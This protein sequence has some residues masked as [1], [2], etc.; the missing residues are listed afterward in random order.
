LNHVTIIRALSLLSAINVSYAG[1][2]ANIVILTAKQL[3][4]DAKAVERKPIQ[5]L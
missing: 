3:F 1:E 5:T 4:E 2:K